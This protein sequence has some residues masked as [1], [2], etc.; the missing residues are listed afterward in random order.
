MPSCEEVRRELSDY[1]DGRHGFM[2]RM[3]LR[4]HLAMCDQCAKAERALRDTVSLL[5]ALRD[6]PIDDGEGL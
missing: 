2:R 6:E 1:I 5:G 4:A 3:V